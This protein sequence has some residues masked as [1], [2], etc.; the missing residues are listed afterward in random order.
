MLY[1]GNYTDTKTS[2]TGN[3]ITLTV[4]LTTQASGANLV[5]YAETNIAW[6]KTGFDGSERLHI[7]I[8][9][10]STGTE[11]THDTFTPS[12]Q[13]ATYNL[14]Y[15]AP[16]SG[17]CYAI[18]QLV[19]NNS[20]VPAIQSRSFGVAPVS[21]NNITFTNIGATTADV[22][23]TTNYDCS[24]FYWSLDN[25]TWTAMTA[26]GTTSASASIT[27]LTNSVANTVYFKATRSDILS[28]GTGSASVTT[29]GTAQ[30]ISAP[31]VE[32]DASSVS[33]SFLVDVYSTAYTYSFRVM[34]GATQVTTPLSVT[35]TSTGEQ[36]K[37]VSLSSTRRNAILSAMSSVKSMTLTYELS[38]TIS[39]TTTTSTCDGLFYTSAAKSAPT[40]SNPQVFI[41]DTATYE[42]FN[43][44]NDITNGVING[45]TT[46]GASCL[47]GATARNQASIAYYYITVGSVETRNST[48][49]FSTD[50]VG[51]GGSSIE[52]VYGAVDTRGY[53]VK[54]SYTVPVW[55]YTPMYWQQTN[56][57]RRNGYDNEIDFTIRAKYDPIEATVGGTTYDN[58]PSTSIA[59]RYSTDN[60]TTW[61]ST[62]LVGT[63]NT[64]DNTVDYT[65]TPLNITN[66][67]NV[68]IELTA[69]DLLS[70]A[71]LSLTV[72]KGIPLI[73]IIDGK[74]IINGDLEVNGTIINNP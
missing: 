24:S 16:A 2:S 14:T 48:N 67:A 38:T 62:T 25:S 44:S 7:Y 59:M 52:I 74:V 27:G 53:E 65:G 45:V 15:T 51:F 70:S 31:D 23:V 29:L 37:T 21:F 32:I 40:W 41:S 64:T 54:V 22:S 35:F 6:S 33:L 18:V 63:N 72:P 46:V 34:N 47:N 66:T 39:G 43:N 30:M 69:N 11:V 26:N 55:Q 17:A 5:L 42:F 57:A 9:D 71:P 19:W 3:V 1:I 12:Q 61:S 20:T 50:A 56:I 36:T 8:Y 68:L 49:I 13:H 73:Q 60:G 4:D 58:V 28:V 10:S